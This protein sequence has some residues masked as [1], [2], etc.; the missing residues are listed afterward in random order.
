MVWWSLW[1][2]RVWFTILC[3]ESQLA[4]GP[5]DLVT[6]HRL[7][8]GIGLQ[9]HLEFVSSCVVEEPARPP[10]CQPCCTLL[11]KQ[12]KCLCFTAAAA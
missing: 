1:C 8:L 4:S 12:L 11:G 5:R 3:Q 2:G 6:S 7:D 9:L 10:A